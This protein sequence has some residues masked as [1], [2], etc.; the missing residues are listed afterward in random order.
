MDQEIWQKLMT[1]ESQ[2]GV[3]R[4]YNKIHKK[5]LN[6]R[7]SI[8]ICAAVKQAREYFRNASNSTYAVRPL[9]TFYGVSSLARAATLIFK[10]KGGEEGLTSGHGLT[11]VYWSED[12]SG[13]LSPALQQ[14]GNLR[15]K[16]NSGLFFD[17][18]KETKNRSC[19]HTQS[20]SVDWM[21]D[22]PVLEE[23]VIFSLN[24]VLARLPDLIEDYTNLTEKNLYAI[25]NDFKYTE[26]DGFQCKVWSKE[27]EHFRKWYDEN[28]YEIIN[29]GKHSIIKTDSSNFKKNTAVFVHSYV[30]KMFRS[31]PS[32][33]MSSPIGNFQIS[34]LGLTF[35]ASYYLGMLVRYYPTHWSQLINGGSGDIYWPILNRL[36]NYVEKAFPELVIELKTQVSE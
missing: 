10:N 25:A 28:G 13:D 21:L 35:L 34:Q 22:Y 1:L 18:I 2:E 36:E 27:F 11:T 17:F 29:D 30:N 6:T 15:V 20:A 3:K 9:L 32:I 24:D 8:E 26:K 19:L 31:I 5:T 23:K 33:H 4:I 16:S 12:L 7:R 14:L